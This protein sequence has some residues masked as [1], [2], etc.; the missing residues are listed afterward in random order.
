[1]ASHKLAKFDVHR[2]CGSGDIMNDFRLSHDL[3]RPRD[4]MVI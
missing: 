4:Q 1:M 2:V 3:T